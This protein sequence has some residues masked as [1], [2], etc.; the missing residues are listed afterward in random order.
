MKKTRVNR[1]TYLELF[2]D[3]YRDLH[4]TQEPRE[5]RHETHK[6]MRANY[7]QAREK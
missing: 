2:M 5:A 6:F 1:K 4:Q 7:I 3:K